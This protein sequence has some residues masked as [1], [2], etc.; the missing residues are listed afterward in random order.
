MIK[1]FRNET[2]LVDLHVVIGSDI[3]DC[4]SEMRTK[5]MLDSRD[6][7]DQDTAAFYV[8]N[9]SNVSI[10]I[11]NSDCSIFENICHE[12][13]HI[14]LYILNRAGMEHTRETDEVFCYLAG[15]AYRSVLSALTSFNK[16]RF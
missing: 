3:N 5:K 2:F 1:K 15:W 16:N 7:F 13:C 10:A 11:K 14:S 4:I 8:C 12:V 6:E 9:G